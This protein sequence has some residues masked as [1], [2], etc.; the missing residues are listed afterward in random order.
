GFFV[1][2]GDAGP[3]VALVGVVGAAGVVGFGEL[4]RHRG[5]VGQ[6]ETLVAVL[7]AMIVLAPLVSV[8]PGG[9]ADPMVSSGSGGPETIEAGLLTGGDEV[10]VQGSISLS[11][12]VR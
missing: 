12:K 8:V 5:S 1:L 9:A 6:V 4:E 10:S 11:P 2:T 7:A 3:I